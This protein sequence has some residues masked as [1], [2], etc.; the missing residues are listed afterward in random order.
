M[1]L[2]PKLGLGKRVITASRDNQ[3]QTLVALIEAVGH[4]VKD[5]LRLGISAEADPEATAT[6]KALKG[7]PGGTPFSL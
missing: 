7:A 3:A 6:R 4:R 2:S 5:V 1:N